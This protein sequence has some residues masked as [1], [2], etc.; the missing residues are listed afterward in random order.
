MSYDAIRIGVGFRG[1][2]NAKKTSKALIGVQQHLTE[3]RFETLKRSGER[4]S[5][6][7]GPSGV[8][9]KGTRSIGFN[10]P[11]AMNKTSRPSTSRSAS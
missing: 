10:I 4:Y 1:G 7:H 2:H 6:P 3:G 5:V 8:S 11:K 9:R